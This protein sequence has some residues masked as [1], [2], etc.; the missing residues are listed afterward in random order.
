MYY[1]PHDYFH[2]LEE[3]LRQLEQENEQLKDK[4]SHLH[5]VHVENITYKVQEL[6]VEHLTGTLNIGL[7]ALSDA[8]QI[9]RWMEQ[10]D[11]DHDVNIQT[12]NPD[13]SDLEP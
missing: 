1:P 6:H 7:T 2:K 3:R 8:E 12:T 11:A 9:K 5:P 4:I 13:K 10:D